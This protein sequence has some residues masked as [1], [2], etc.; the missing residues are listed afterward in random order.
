MLLAGTHLTEEF[1]A[2]SGGVD[3]A[4][5]RFLDLDVDMNF[6]GGKYSGE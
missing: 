1:G 6:K 2:V 3:F 4:A 5:K